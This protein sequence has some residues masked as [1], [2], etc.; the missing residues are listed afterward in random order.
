MLMRNFLISF[1]FD[2]C[3]MLLTVSIENFA[4]KYSLTNF[5]FDGEHQFD[6]F[7]IVKIRYV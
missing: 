3:E 1:N 7:G 4:R 6:L 5:M 2:A